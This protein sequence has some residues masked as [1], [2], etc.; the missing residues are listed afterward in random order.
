MTSCRLDGK[1]ITCVD[2]YDK[3]TK[4]SELNNIKK[5]VSLSMMDDSSKMWPRTSG[6]S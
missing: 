2:L 1:H 3:T 4:D 5:I 6:E